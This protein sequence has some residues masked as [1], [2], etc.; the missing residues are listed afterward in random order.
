MPLTALVR[1]TWLTV[2]VL[3]LALT[4]GGCGQDDD[5]GGDAGVARG[6]SSAPPDSA[7]WSGNAEADPTSGEV[8]AAAFNRYLED[9]GPPVSTSPCD[10]ARVFLHLDRPQEEGETVDLRVEPEDAPEATVTV[11]FDNLADDSVA[12][13]RWTLQFEPAEDDS[14]RLARGRVG[15]RCQPGR[16][17]QDFSPELCI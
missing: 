11:T 8:D 17:H 15:Q 9:A 5:E 4:L 2:G 16:G 13:V 7:S 3:G 6:C 1:A 12:A 14:I 10:A